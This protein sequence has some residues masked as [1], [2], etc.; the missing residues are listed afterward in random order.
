MATTKPTNIDE[1]IA[2]FPGEVQKEM[3]QLRSLIHELVPKAE[4]TISYAMPTFNLNGSY[5]VYFAGFK[6]HIG[7]YPAPVDNDDFAKDL[8]GYKTGR[9]SVQLP[10]G[11]PLPV[12]LITK[13]VKF[14]LKQNK[15]RAKTKK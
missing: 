4:E 13:I 5:V 6:N 15:E 3:Q 8:E 1:Y 14:Q 2:T 10:L 7:L 9:G 12:K 11:E